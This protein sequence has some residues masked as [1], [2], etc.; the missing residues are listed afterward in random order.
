MSQFVTF[1]SQV[2]IYPINTYVCVCGGGKQAV[3]MSVITGE[4]VA[5]VRDMEDKMS[6]V[7]EPVH[8][9]VTHWTKDMWS[10]MSY[11]FVKTWRSGEAYDILAEDV[12]GQVFFAGEATNRHFPPTVTRAYL[13]G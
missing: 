2:L 3:L 4:A 12:Q 8:F 11:S 7:P 5:A 6:E 9:F 1:F 13:N 10:Q